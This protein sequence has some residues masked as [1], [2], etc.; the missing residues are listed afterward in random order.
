M[1]RLAACS[2]VCGFCGRCSGAWE[3]GGDPEQVSFLT[4][5]ECGGDAFY[6]RSLSGVGVFCSDKCANRAC[7]KHEA[8]M[9]Q[10]EFYS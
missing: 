5:D 10:R 6:P 3:G 7:L 2:H 1:A 8:R 4:C 9:T